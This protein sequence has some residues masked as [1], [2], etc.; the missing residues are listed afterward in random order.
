MNPRERA[1]L[2][3]IGDSLVKLR[4]NTEHIHDQARLDRL[5]AEIDSMIVEEDED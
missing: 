2:T 5:I 3:R 4:L 1:R